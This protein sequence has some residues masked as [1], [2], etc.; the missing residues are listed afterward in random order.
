[1]KGTKIKS[2]VKMAGWAGGGGGGGGEGGLVEIG[3]TKAG[4]EQRHKPGVHLDLR[5]FLPDRTP[6]GIYGSSDP[7][8]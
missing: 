4:L 6:T 8:V 2:E 3:Q 7:A 5:A 1:M